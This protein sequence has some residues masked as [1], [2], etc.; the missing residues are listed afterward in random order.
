M[1]AT[2]TC[3]THEPGAKDPVFQSCLPPHQYQSLHYHRTHARNPNKS[4]WLTTSADECHIFCTALDEEWRDDSGCLW[5]AHPDGRVLGVAGERIATFPLPGQNI[6][7]HGFPVAGHK[8]AAM[9]RHVPPEVLR[10]WQE[11]DVTAPSLLTKLWKRL[12]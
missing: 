9:R 8:D 5:F 3:S 11:H 7:W 12:I 2:R 6:P 4:R 1:I 10:D